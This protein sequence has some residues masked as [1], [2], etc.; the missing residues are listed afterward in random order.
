VAPLPQRDD[1]E[2]PAPPEP[3]EQPEHNHTQE[4]TTPPPTPKD[5]RG[6]PQPGPIQQRP[7]ITQNTGHFLDKQEE[8]KTHHSSHKD[9]AAPKA[10]APKSLSELDEE[11]N[12]G[13]WGTKLLGGILGKK[14]KRKKDE[15]DTIK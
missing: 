4:A 11:K 5:S 9:I 7:R 12:E 10:H 8:R 3:K 15:D 14:E 1:S 6:N 13:R 2:A